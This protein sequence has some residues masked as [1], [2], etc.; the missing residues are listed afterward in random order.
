MEYNNL[1]LETARTYSQST[2]N[3]NTYTCYEAAIN[4]TS[5][6][7]LS[8]MTSMEAGQTAL[9]QG[10]YQNAT[11]FLTKAF[12]LAETQIE[13]SLSGKTSYKISFFKSMKFY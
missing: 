5:D 4:S 10:D 13:K 7:C 11:G 6:S 3:A 2:E 8:W 9:L 1:F 12:K